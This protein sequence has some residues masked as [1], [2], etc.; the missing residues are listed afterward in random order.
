MV[1]AYVVKVE[2]TGE[3][4]FAISRLFFTRGGQRSESQRQNR[5]SIREDA[6]SRERLLL[7]KG[8]IK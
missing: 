1:K 5:N 4:P 8:H 7:L 2:N 6:L 3:I